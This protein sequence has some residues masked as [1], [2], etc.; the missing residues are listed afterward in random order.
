VRAARLGHAVADAIVD[1][2]KEDGE[3]TYLHALRIN[4]VA[5]VMVIEHMLLPLE[6]AAFDGTTWVRAPG[7]S[8]P[9]PTGDLPLLDDRRHVAGVLHRCHEPHCQLPLLPC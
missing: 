5:V 8:S 2:I 6:A 1:A 7:V 4:R 9:H 3:L